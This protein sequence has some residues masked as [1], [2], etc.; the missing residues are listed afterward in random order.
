MT[1]IDLASK[2][3]SRDL[4]AIIDDWLDGLRVNRARNSAYRQTMRE[5]GGL[6]DRELAD[7]GVQRSDIAE[8]ARKVAV[9]AA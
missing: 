3:R 7:I 5:L 8:I 2:T 1:A 6:S 4:Y 9:T